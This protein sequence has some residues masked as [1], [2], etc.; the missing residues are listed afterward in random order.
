MAATDRVGQ[1]LRLLAAVVTRPQ[2]GKKMG[3][4]ATAD[5]ETFLDG[6]DGDVVSSETG[7]DG[8]GGGMTT[9][10]DATG[11]TGCIVL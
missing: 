4:P 7:A 3:D 8:P 5:A 10:S 2:S 11:S 9:E 1:Y 6:G